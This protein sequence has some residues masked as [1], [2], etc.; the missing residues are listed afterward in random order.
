[1]LKKGKANYIFNQVSTTF[2]KNLVS[3]NG[4]LRNIIWQDISQSGL[5]C[6]L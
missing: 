3:P 4:L 1:M 6:L 2:L 5:C